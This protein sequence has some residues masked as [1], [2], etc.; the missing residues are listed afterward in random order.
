MPIEATWVGAHC[1]NCK[2]IIHGIAYKDQ[3]IV[4]AYCETCDENV[5]FT[6]PKEKKKKK[7]KKK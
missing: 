3:K 4:Q 2:N 1:P 5:S 6:V 7:E